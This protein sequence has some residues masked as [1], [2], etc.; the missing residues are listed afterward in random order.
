MSNED[1]HAQIDVH[2]ADIGIKLPFEDFT[3]A[4]SLKSA[5]HD[6]LGGEPLFTNFTGE[7]KTF[8][9]AYSLPANPPRISWPCG[10]A[11]SIFSASL[12]HDLFWRT[13]FVKLTVCGVVLPLHDRDLG[14]YF[15]F[16]RR[17]SGRAGCEVCHVIPVNRRLPERGG[18]AKLGVPVGPPT[19]H[20]VLYVQ[21][22]A[23]TCS[24]VIGADHPKR[25]YP[26]ARLLRIFLLVTLWPRAMHVTNQLY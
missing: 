16:G 20:C 15:L 9:G 19:A 24:K 13:T 25:V 26:P 14:L 18:V 17:W 22:T 11:L 6:I 8:A 4:R 10:V 23:A 5:Y 7:P 21:G 12:V 2:D 3:H 1:P